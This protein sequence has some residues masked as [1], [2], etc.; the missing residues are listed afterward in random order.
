MPPVI[1]RGC[2]RQGGNQLSVAEC[3]VMSSRGFFYGGP[4]TG[5]AR[6]SAGSSCSRARRRD[7]Y[8]V[9]GRGARGGRFRR[10]GP[11]RLQRDAVSNPARSRPGRPRVL[12]RGRSRHHRDQ[13]LRSHPARP[14]RIRDRASRERNQPGRD[15]A[16]AGSCRTLV[17]PGESPVRVWRDGSDDPG[18]EC[19]RRGHIR[20]TGGSLSDP[21]TRTPGRRRRLPAPRDMPGHA[22]H[23]GGTAGDRLRF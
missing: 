21:V 10:P 14:R 6:S 2:G 4:S 18:L 11:R 8:A 17:V 7:R 12:S 20:A 1:E 16:G 13:H 15:G 5:S 23:Q 19:H 9:S 22:K 3:L